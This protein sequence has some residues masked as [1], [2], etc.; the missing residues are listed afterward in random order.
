[1]GDIYVG[2]LRRT[3]LKQNQIGD[4]MLNK[5]LMA[6]AMATALVAAPAVA[7]T[8]TAPGTDRPAATGA[9]GTTVGSPAMQPGAAGGAGTAAETSGAAAGAG[10][11]ATGQRTGMAPLAAPSPG[12]MMGS[13]VRG[14][15]V[16]GV[17]NENVGSIS[18]IVI[19]QNGQVAALIVGV[20]GFLG[21]G[22]KDVAIPFQAVE[23]VADQG[24]A[25]AGATGLPLG[26]GMG[27]AGAGDPAT[28]GTVGTTGTP[29]GT[30][31]GATAGTVNP[32]RIVLRHM[33]KADL[34]AA[35]EFRS[36]DRWTTGGTGATGTG[37]GAVGAGATGAG[38]AGT[39]A[40]GGTAPRQ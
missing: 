1:M 11:M 29:T 34:E 22:Q 36:D 23:I 35:P 9:G 28:T 31:A 20:G 21:I 33:T 38:G 15:R 26:T 27:G 37:T 6:C 18:D 8:T 17:N 10:S 16:Y 32:N 3:L 24:V 14:T 13:D 40:A 39:G 4:P 19:D 30:G 2:V 25:G 5:H 7:Q 12:Q